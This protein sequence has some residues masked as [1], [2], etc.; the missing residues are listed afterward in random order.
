MN[1]K[2]YSYIQKPNRHGKRI[3]IKE[4]S[5]VN[6]L[7]QDIELRQKNKEGPIISPFGAHNVTLA[8][9]KLFINHNTAVWHK[10]NQRYSANNCKP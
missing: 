10:P 5:V 2:T 3:A 9:E 8:T 7:A 1:G 4:Y 6:C